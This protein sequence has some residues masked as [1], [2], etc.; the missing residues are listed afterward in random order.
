[1]SARPELSHDLHIH[2]LCGAVRLVASPPVLCAGHCHCDNCR[3]THGAAMWTWITFERERVTPEPGSE[4]LVDY[5]SVSGATRSFCGRCGTS[6]AYRSPDAP[7]E[8]DLSLANVV[9]DYSPKFVAHCWAG[10][11]PDWHPIPDDGL[12]R[13]ERGSASPELT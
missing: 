10:R 5:L 1:M 13:T 3:W 8:V 9:E 6:L 2:C 12:P 11:A 7:T 4:P